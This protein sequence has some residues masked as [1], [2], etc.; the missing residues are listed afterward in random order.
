MLAIIVL[1]LV[2]ASST[3]ALAGI[4]YCNNFKHNIHIALAFE[5]KDG[6]ERRLDRHQGQFVLGR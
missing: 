4:K 6:R 1:F 3:P 2:L 5:T